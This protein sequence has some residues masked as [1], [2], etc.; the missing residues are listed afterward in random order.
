MTAFKLIPG[1]KS[2][3]IFGTLPHY[4]LTKEYNFDRLHWNGK[5]K[6]DK[7]GPL[8]RESIVPGVDILWLYRPEDIKDM[9]KVRLMI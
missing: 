9:F 5:K 7:F 3:P 1:P 4:F 6:Y 2:Y 8:V